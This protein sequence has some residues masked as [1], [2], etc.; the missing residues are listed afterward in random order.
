MFQ[1]DANGA[2]AVDQAYAN[3][4]FFAGYDSPFTLSDRHN[5]VWLPVTGA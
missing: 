2:L 4:W 1:V 5:E 3:S